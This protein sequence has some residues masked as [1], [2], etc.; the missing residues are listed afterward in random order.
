M[1]NTNL[2]RILKA[3]A[4]PRR[5]EIFNLLVVTASALSITQISQHFEISRQG[6]TKH[7]NVLHEAG[8]IS[9]TS[10]GRERYCNA[11]PNS[12]SAVKDWAA[13]YDQFWDNK[14]DALERH[15]A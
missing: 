1:S 11:I 10:E 9:T 12:L 15:L 3:I 8:L 7:I 4:D 2:D 5:R 6:V 14:L 13:F